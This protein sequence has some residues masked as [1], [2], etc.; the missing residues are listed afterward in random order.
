MNKCPIPVVNKF[1]FLTSIPFT[2]SPPNSPCFPSSMSS[3]PSEERPACHLPSHHGGVDAGAGW[4]LHGRLLIRRGRGLGQ[5]GPRPEGPADSGLPEGG[6]ATPPGFQLGP[7]AGGDRL[8]AG[9]LLQAA[10]LGPSGC[11]CCSTA[12]TGQ[13]PG[14]N[15][16]PA[17][18]EPVCGAASAHA[19]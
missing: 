8:R 3:W 5:R 13:G 19:R 4:L 9:K 6:S 17:L 15:S 18:G 7:A 2:A 1:L 12:A 11:G 14:S 16:G 10:Q